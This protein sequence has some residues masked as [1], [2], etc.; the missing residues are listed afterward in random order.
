LLFSATL[1]FEAAWALTNI[2]SGT[3]DQT[4]AV[5]Q[6]GAVPHFLK[7]LESQSINVCEQAVW[8]LGNIIGII[9]NNKIIKAKEFKA[10]APISAT[11]ASSWALFSR[12]SNLLL[13]TS[14][15]TF[16]AMSPGLVLYQTVFLNLINI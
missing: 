4:R 14:R 1:Q 7:L 3:S 15:L 13:R 8:A 9:R 5:V 10:M 6:A 12:C 2:A 16:C 11:I